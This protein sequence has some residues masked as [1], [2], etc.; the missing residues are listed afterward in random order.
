MFVTVIK[1]VLIICIL[2]RSVPFKIEA[3]IEFNDGEA[4]YA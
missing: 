1:S 3:I 2:S 4:Y